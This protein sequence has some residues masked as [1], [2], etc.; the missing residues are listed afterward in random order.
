LAFYLFLEFWPQ[1]WFQK[2]YTS[3]QTLINKEKN[4]GKISFIFPPP[5]STEGNKGISPPW[6]PSKCTF[7]LSWIQ[8]YLLILSFIHT[9]KL[10]DYSIFTCFKVVRVCESERFNH[11]RIHGSL[12][13][14][15]GPELRNCQR[16]VFINCQSQLP[17][18]FSKREWLHVCVSV[19]LRPNNFSLCEG[20]AVG[21]LLYHTKFCLHMSENREDFERNQPWSLFLKS[22]GQASCYVGFLESKPIKMHHMHFF[23]K[24]SWVFLLKVS[25]SPNFNRSIW[26]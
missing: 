17:R 4:R 5:S 10:K 20:K 21:R 15:K 22:F 24:K 16:N 23:A 25:S 19:E 26:N 14:F 18:S 2:Y 6:G 9:C 8:C 1:I 7:C 3:N 13:K 11:H 12:I